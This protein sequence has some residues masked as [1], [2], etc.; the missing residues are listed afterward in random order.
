[1]QIIAGTADQLPAGLLF[2]MARYRHAVF[3]ERLG[4][5][6]Q[7][8]GRLELDQFDRRDTVYVLAVNAAGKLVGMTRLLP[9]ARPY[10]LADVFPQLLGGAP[11]P[12]SPQVW[13]LSRFAA[14]DPEATASRAQ[15]TFVSPLAL[16]I[17]SVAMSVAADEGATRLISVSP[18]GVERIL[19]HAG[20]VNERAGPPIRIEGRP[21]VACWIK[22]Q[23]D[24]RPLREATAAAPP[25]D[26]KT[27]SV[28]RLN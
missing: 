19:R 23:R 12:R 24:W 2:D 11:L 4:W 28:Q 7:P 16:D 1:M 15:L 14:L 26:T 3:V 6:L 13:E 17:L 9:T 21:L 20:L 8:T 27:P 10:L 22:V 25:T 5:Q 18:V